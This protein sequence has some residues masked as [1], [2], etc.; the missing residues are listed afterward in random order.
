M[1]WQTYVDMLEHATYAAA[2]FSIKGA[3]CAKS[4]NFAGNSKNLV[5]Q[6]KMFSDPLLARQHGI[7]YNDIKMFSLE[8]SNDFIHAMHD[9]L[10]IY[11]KKANSVIV[12][13]L[14]GGDKPQN[15]AR[16][17]VINIAKILSDSGA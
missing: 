6:S 7:E 8:Y 10:N 15:D 17:Q 5:Y 16:N 12:V 3:L 11:M 14:C 4:S 9:E 1:S 2:I 13:G